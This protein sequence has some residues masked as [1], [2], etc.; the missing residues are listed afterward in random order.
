MQHFEAMHA[1]MARIQHLQAFLSFSKLNPTLDYE[2][3]N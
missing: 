2:F 1:S 3:D